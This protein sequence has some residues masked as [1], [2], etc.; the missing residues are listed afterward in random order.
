[1]ALP[2]ILRPVKTELIRC[3]AKNDGG[4]LVSKKSIKSA[5]TLISFGILDDCSFE[6]DFLKI[7]DIP[8]FCFDKINYKTYWKKRIYN[9]LGA[10]LFNLNFQFIKNTFTKYFKLNA[11]FKLKNVFVERKLIKENDLNN[12][13]HLNESIK[14]PIFL[15]IDIEGAEYRILEDILKNKEK[16]E[17][18]IIEFHDVDLHLNKIEDFIKKLNFKV[19]HIH[20]NNYERI[21]DGI[22][23]VIELT[24]EKNPLIEDEYASLPNKNDAPCNPKKNELK[25]NFCDDGF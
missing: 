1:M 8:I 9:D 17:T 11:F 13:I 20:A 18:I 7:K 3:G 19:T 2:N 24:L 5:N 10:G 21:I 15:K 23:L 22:P 12:L 4:Y 25:L 16:I 6:N 14:S